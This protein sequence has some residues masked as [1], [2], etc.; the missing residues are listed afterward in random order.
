MK[1]MGTQCDFYHSIFFNCSAL[2]NTS[3]FITSL[4]IG[5]GKVLL[6]YLIDYLDVVIIAEEKK[7]TYEAE[8]LFGALKYVPGTANEAEDNSEATATE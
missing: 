6:K 1:R 4:I 3:N 7:E 2:Y 8:M 5:R